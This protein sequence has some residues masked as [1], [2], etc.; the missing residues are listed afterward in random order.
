M[1]MKF[2]ISGGTGFIGRHILTRLRRDGHHVALWSR[3]GEPQLDVLNGADAVLH[4][5]GEPVAQRWTEQAK[6]RIRDGRVM[7]TR[8]LVGSIAAA[9]PRPKV[10]V[11]TSAIGFYGD[12]GDEILSEI[13]QPG[14]GFLADVCQGW[15]AEAD[16]ATAFDVRVTKLRVGFVLGKE[17]GAL[18]QM[19]PIFR[20]GLGGRLGSG[21][22]W[23]P[24]IHVD[25]VA[26]LFVHAATTEIHGVWNATAPNP[27][28][29]DI[30]TK[31]MAG[32]IHRPAIFPV[33]RFALSLGFGEFG[34]HMLDSARVIPAHALQA[35]Y[36][37]RYPELG[38]ALRNL[39]T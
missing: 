7:G 26:D 17:G 11:S 9:S 30:F 4:L 3:H 19:L 20:L 10:L 6:Q 22:Q 27:V 33:P 35:G 1:R 39:L 38:Q 2:V 15:E 24:W 32:V 18:A 14:T 21:K 13:S 34:G 12:R 23:M 37:F 36:E 8:R 29:N 5:A 16:R 31:E 25:D 28:T